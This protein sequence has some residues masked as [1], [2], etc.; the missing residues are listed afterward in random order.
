MISFIAE[1]KKTGSRKLVSNDIEYAVEFRSDDPA[2]LKL[3]EI[4]ADRTVR[5]KV[6]F[7]D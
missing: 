6:T 1:I 4:Q 3:G 2:V 5:V 7:E